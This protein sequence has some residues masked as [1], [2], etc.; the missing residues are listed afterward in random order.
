MFSLQNWFVSYYQSQVSFYH[1]LC[2]TSIPLV[3]ATEQFRKPITSEA[4][5]KILLQGNRQCGCVHRLAHSLPSCQNPCIRLTFIDRVAI[6]YKNWMASVVAVIGSTPVTAK[7]VS[8][9]G[10]F[11]RSFKNLSL[12]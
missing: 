11:M 5:K 10:L 6:K 1:D 7:E 8:W 4:K 12:I 9:L 3:Y 2:K